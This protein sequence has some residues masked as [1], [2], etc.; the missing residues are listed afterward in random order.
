MLAKEIWVHLLGYNLVRQALAEAARAAGVAPR[1]LS[2]AGAVQALEAFRWLLQG[3]A[4]AAFALACQALYLAI[5][6]HRV[7]KRPGRV[8]PRRVKR[9]QQLYPLLQQARAAARAALL[10]NAQ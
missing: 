4:G 1:Q 6:A 9:R 5:G 8:E 2:F 7:G 3:S 10:A